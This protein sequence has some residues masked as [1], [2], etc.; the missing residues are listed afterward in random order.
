M[1]WFSRFSL[2][3]GIIFV[4][5]S[6]ETW[7]QGYEPDYTG[8]LDGTAHWSAPA[9]ADIDG[10][11]SNGLEI[12]TA[13]TRGSVAV[14]NSSTGVLWQALVPGAPCPGSSY[15]Q[16][17]PAVADID[18]DGV[19]EVVIGYGPIGVTSC[20]GGVVAF[21]GLT[22]AVKWIFNI[23]NQ[24]K[25]ENFHSV[26]ATPS[27]GDVNGDGLLEVA[28]GGLD[29]FFY[30]LS[31]AGKKVF[32]YQAG[33]T[34]FSSPLFANIDADP[35]LEVVA[36]TDISRNKLAGTPNGGV[37]Y[38]FEVGKLSGSTKSCK[39]FKKK[40]RRRKCKRRK[41]QKNKGQSRSSRVDHTFLS[42]GAFKWQTFFDQVLQA[43]P[44]VADFVSTNE[45]NEVAIATGCFFPEESSAKRGK[46]MKILSART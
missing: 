10:N 39:R 30:V 46:Y 23:K 1:F 7:A 29:R 25:R 2:V 8:A 21:N 17:S 31:H 20:T 43:S 22:G 24:S 41:R 6:V 4:F 34:I 42:P 11:A 36:T 38:G 35:E 28:F 37:A 33:D 16:S 3:I 26:I 32:R 12:V 44:V 45:G 13:T 18:N 40:K 19:K 5:A 9:L 15:V 14:H 27:L